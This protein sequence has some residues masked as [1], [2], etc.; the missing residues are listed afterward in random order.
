MNKRV[1]K[2]SLAIYWH[3]HQPVYEL[4]G[5]YLMPWV[6]LHAVKDYL[7][8]VLIL[9]KF[10]K[11]KLN[12]NI[13][14]ALLDAILDYTENGYHDIHSELTVSDTE[15]LTDEEKAFILNN[16]FSSKYET[17]IYRSEN[18]KELY[19]KRFAKDVAAIEDFSAQEF[20]DLMA[21]FNLVWI[22]PVHFE[23]YPRLQELW[24]KQNGYTQQDRVEI[25]DIQKQ[26][27]R[28][29][30][31]AY[32][33]YIQTGRIELTTSPYYHSILP[34]LIDVKSSTKNVITIEDGTKINGLGTAIE[35]LIVENNLQDIKF[36]KQAWPDEFL[37]QGTEWRKDG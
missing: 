5:T 20:S 31:P 27:I 29:I 17:M 11:L 37:K 7:D 3:M 9:E 32:K 23:R 18:Y 14:P 19:Q 22:D 2:L 8:M 16:F 26:I 6:R 30:I 33:K 13:V 15:N 34:I 4:E 1:K 36:E 25:I 12:F 35:E 24:E 21:L 28:E 10:P